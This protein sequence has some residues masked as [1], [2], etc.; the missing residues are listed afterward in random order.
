MTTTRD[1]V[2]GAAAGA[3]P[4]VER[5]LRDDELHQSLRNAY[6]SGRALYNGLVARHGVTDAATR[7]ATD[8]DVQG[9]LRTAIE[10]LRSAAGRLQGAERKR[11]ENHGARNALFLL[12]GITVGLLLNPVSGPK[13]R[14]LLGRVVFVGDD[15]SFVYGDNGAGATG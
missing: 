1:R 4:Y 3:R 7:L 12:A 2:A 15:D 13:L 8:K 5:A 10:E 6:A 14:R 9:E 11:D